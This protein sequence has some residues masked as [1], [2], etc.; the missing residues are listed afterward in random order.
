[1]ARGGLDADPRNLRLAYGV[2]YRH[3]PELRW[4]LESA[5]AK[6]ITPAARAGSWPA[7]IRRNQTLGAG[8]VPKHGSDDP[9]GQS[10]VM[11]TLL[12]QQLVNGLVLGSTYAFVALGLT[13]VFGV[14]LIPNFAHGELFMLGAFF[15]S[16][17]VGFGADFW[18][19]VCA[20]TLAVGLVGLVLDQLA[21]KPIENAPHLSLLISA[22]AASTI[23]AQVA[24]LIWGSGSRITP[25]SID[26]VLRNGWFSVTYLQLVIFVSLLICSALVWLI[27]NHSRLGLA[28][29]AMSQNRSAAALMGIELGHVRIATFVL[30][31]ALGGLSGALL[32]ATLPI[33]TAMGLGPTLKAFVV[34]VLG[35]VGSLPGAILG[36]LGLGLVEVL[37]AGYISSEM[38]DIG[39]FLILVL[40]LMIRPQGVLGQAEVER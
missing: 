2:C 32:G 10:A 5:A 37:V 23:M 4:R 39:T 34:L 16:A 7:A 12:P 31:S 36:G 33:S 11:L 13:L 14:L 22:L 15:T 9:V 20:A 26:G 40:V 24:E 29:R 8:L 6:L 3:V 25:T 17:L 35:G 38:Q 27:I 19:S 21:F 30:A 28:I 18:L 1:M